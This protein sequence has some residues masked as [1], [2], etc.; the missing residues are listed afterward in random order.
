M[1]NFFEAGTTIKVSHDLYDHY[2]ISDGQGG[3]IHNS[4]KKGCVSHVTINEFSNGRKVA[5]SNI[6]GDSLQTAF[7]NAK[8]YLSTPYILFSSNCEH[9]VRVAHGLEKESV[10][11]QKFMMLAL[12]IGVAVNSK[13][14]SL[15]TAGIGAIIGSLSTSPEESPLKSAVLGG[16][17]GLGLEY[18]HKNCHQ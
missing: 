4:K 15:K 3:V 16:L 6:C 12:G 13:D 18:I 7:D 11:L 9:F 10:Q 8:K 17:I 1:N 5:T 14:D 2:G